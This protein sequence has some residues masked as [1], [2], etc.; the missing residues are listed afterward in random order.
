MS[1]FMTQ[2]LVTLLSLTGMEIV[3]GI[4]NI[5]FMSLLV[6]KLPPREQP[7]ARR[8]GLILALGTRLLLLFSLSMMMRLT[9]PF[10]FI[11]GHGISGRDLIL[12]LGGLF[13]I[14]KSTMEI[15]ER[16]EL[17]TVNVKAGKTGVRSG[18]IILQIAVL[19]IVFSLDSVVTAV[20]MAQH[21]WIMVA[22]MICAV[23]VML[24]AAAEV[25]RFVDT[26]PTVKLLA[27]SFLILIGVAL[28][29]DGVGGHIPKGYIYFAMFF[30]F[31][32]EMLN[33]YIKKKQA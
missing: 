18:I 29:V 7:S 14:A 11:W 25:G 21:L 1:G 10:F 32:V 3:L 24:F 9:T 13:L 16:L 17:E 33:I 4:D 2:D 5:I 15:H 28:L 12:I 27:L 31:S 30:S 26:H 23:G 19:D 20:G 6:A 8:I 22:A